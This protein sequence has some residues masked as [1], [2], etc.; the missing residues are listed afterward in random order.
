MRYKILIL[1]ILILQNLSS[2]SIKVA[3][4]DLDV[5]LDNNYFA[6][7]KVKNGKVYAASYKSDN[8]KVEISVFEVSTMKKVS[9]F[10]T[11]KIKN[12]LDENGVLFLENKI[13]LIRSEKWL[14]PNII[15]D[16]YDYEGKNISKDNSLNNFKVV[17]KFG[18]RNFGDNIVSQNGKYFMITSNNIPG[19]AG[20]EHVIFDENLKVVSKGI[21]SLPKA[22]INSTIER[23]VL[24]N[25]A[26]VGIF[27]Y[28]QEEENSSFRYFKL[29]KGSKSVEEVKVL[30]ESYQPFKSQIISSKDGYFIGGTYGTFYNV[31]QTISNTNAGHCNYGAF[32]LQLDLDNLSIIYSNFSEF[33]PDQVK[34]YN[35]QLLQ[36]K[37]TKKI[38]L[39]SNP[40][41]RIYNE[42]YRLIIS[43]LTLD[44]N[45]NIVLGLTSYSYEYSSSIAI[46]QL[47]LTA[48]GNMTNFSII[49]KL[50]WLNNPNTNTGKYFPT[51]FYS[52]AIV[53]TESSLVTIFND[54]EKNISNLTDMNKGSSG[55]DKSSLLASAE[56][57]EDG[58][59]KKFILLP[60][61]KDILLYL[62]F[63][64]FIDENLTFMIATRNKETM[65]LLKVSSE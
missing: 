48:D 11:D 34:A 38:F 60:N 15:C 29:D 2:Q 37:F 16:V 22:Q 42:P 21:I 14:G 51:Q 19:K 17:N 18:D 4:A 33:T 54:Q 45:K 7:S 20:F 65:V 57:K 25:T 36:F 61:D 26:N 10:A 62:Y 41:G 50:H 55:V 43:G 58:S 31:K 9:S 30:S 64:T 52:S 35:D 39:K 49:P 53:C 46:C 27:S 1:L 44:K 5:K 40:E 24:S 3:V 8:Y 63:T 6:I 28:V 13:I 56:T 47:K 12:L 32:G 23:L 59:I